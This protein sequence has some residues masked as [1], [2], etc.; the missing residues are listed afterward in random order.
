MGWER[1]SSRE[2]TYESLYTLISTIQW[3]LTKRMRRDEIDSKEIGSLYAANLTRATSKSKNQ[4]TW[5]NER[6][7]MIH[8]P[9]NSLSNGPGQIQEANYCLTCVPMYLA[10]QSRKARYLYVTLPIWYLMHK[11]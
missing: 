11:I 5:N 1:G 8:P 9:F 2:G 10:S 7:V 3:C 4:E 6:K